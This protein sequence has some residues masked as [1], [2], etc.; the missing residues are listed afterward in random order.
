MRLPIVDI[1]HP[2]A[3]TQ[4]GKA[5][6]DSGFFYVV[7]HG[8]DEHLQQRLE[9]ASRQ[10]FALDPETK[11]E[12]RMARGG[13]GWRGYFPVGSELT[14]GLPDLKEGIYF[15]SELDSDHPLVKAGVPLHGPN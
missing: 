3:T 14:S 11:L 10:F 15:G 6:R 1:A 9:A 12:I 5:C 2:D 7:G 13:R 8:V 4:I